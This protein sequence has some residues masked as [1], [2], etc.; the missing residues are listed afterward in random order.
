MVKGIRGRDFRMARPVAQKELPNRLLKRPLHA[1]RGLKGAAVVFCRNGQGG[2]ISW[3]QSAADV[4]FRPRRTGLSGWSALAVALFRWM[5]M[6]LQKRAPLY[7]LT[8]RGG[9]PA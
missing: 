9:E 4:P 8:H 7:L 2:Y 5:D 1:Q 3:R 6:H